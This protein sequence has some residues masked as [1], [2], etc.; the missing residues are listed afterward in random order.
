MKTKFYKSFFALFL[1]SGVMILSLTQ[2]KKVG[3]SDW[4]E[5]NPET[6]N[7]LKVAVYDGEQGSLLNNLSVSVIFPD[8]VME[9]FDAESGKVQFE[10]NQV[11]TY[12][13]T[14][15]KSGF[16]TQSKTVQVEETPEGIVA[17]TKENLY[18]NKIGESTMIAS[19]GGV[20]EIDSDF[21]QSPVLSFPE[22]A[23]ASGAEITATYIPAPAKFGDFVVIGERA[24][25][26]GFSFSPDLTFPEDAKPT[27]EVPVT[28]P[29][30][31]NGDA[32]FL[33]GSFNADTQEW[34]I[35]EGQLNE[36]R[37]MATF[38]MPHFS[39]WYTFTGYRLVIESEWSPYELSGQ[40]ETCSEG[41][42]GTFVYAVNGGS[43]VGDLYEDMYNLDLKAVD[44]RCIGPR[45]LY[46]QQL[47]TRCKLNNYKIYNYTGE[48]RLQ[49]NSYPQEMFNWKVEETYCHHQ[50]WGG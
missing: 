18:L 43:F 33:L 3:T 31:I 26:S 13:I 25:Q 45:Y 38:E 27:L 48:F 42:C 49:L 14:A 39:V 11:G 36:D 21:D 9:E 41:A 4:P 46:A 8:G 34:E 23:V 22:G 12:I 37:T 29:A 6:L 40:S 28:L 16:L 10:G 24:I 32:P 44:T 19:T 20:I 7:E 50:G 47:F 30:V 15:S 2:C 5:P 1:L 17:V 35:I